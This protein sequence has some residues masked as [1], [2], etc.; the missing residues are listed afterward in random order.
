[1]L[2]R[3]SARVRSARY[4]F[5]MSPW[6]V[7]LPWPPGNHQSSWGDALCLLLTWTVAIGGSMLWQ[8][9]RAKYQRWR[10]LK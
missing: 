7:P 2:H 3:R 9:Y 10:K 5:V 1:M 4:T 8:R 6:Y